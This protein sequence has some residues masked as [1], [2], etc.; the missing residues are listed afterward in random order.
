VVSFER[1]DPTVMW[2]CGSVAIMRW[3]NEQRSFALEA[4]FSKKEVSVPHP[5]FMALLT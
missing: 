3:S 2:H 5:V 4:Y 1:G